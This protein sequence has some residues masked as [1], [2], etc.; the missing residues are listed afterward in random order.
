MLEECKISYSS[1]SRLL[2]TFYAWVSSTIILEI[3]ACSINGSGDVMVF[4]TSLEYNHHPKHVPEARLRVPSSPFKTGLLQLYILCQKACF[5]G[6]GKQNNNHKITIL[7]VKKVNSDVLFFPRSTTS[8]TL[9]ASRTPSS[10][11][12]APFS[13]STSGP[14]TTRTMSTVASTWRHPPFPITSLNPTTKRTSTTLAPSVI[15]SRRNR[16][17]FKICISQE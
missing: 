1:G 11:A 13:T 16:F 6:T 3:F 15:A 12:T 10:A 8:A 14:A 4:K 7:K 2:S 17:R 5:K 9:T